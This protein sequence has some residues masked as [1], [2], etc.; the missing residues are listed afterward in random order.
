[1]KSIILSFEK[2][3]TQKMVKNHISALIGVSHRIWNEN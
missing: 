1:M 2:G 3:T